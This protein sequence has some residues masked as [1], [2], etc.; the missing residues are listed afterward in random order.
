MQPCADD[1]LASCDQ[2]WSDVDCLYIRL[3]RIYNQ[4]IGR[5]I[6]RLL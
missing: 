6:E 3:V 5:H 4:L 1:T 2:G